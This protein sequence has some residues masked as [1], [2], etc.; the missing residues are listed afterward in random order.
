[1]GNEVVIEVSAVDGTGPT[2]DE[3][4]ASWLA[5]EKTFKPIDVRATNPINEAFM[6]QVRASIKAISAQ[7]LRIPVDA[8]TAPFLAQVEEVLQ[9]LATSAKADIPLEVGDAIEFRAQVQELVAQIEASTKAV[10]D[11][12][13]NDTG[14]TD[15]QQ[16]TVAASTATTGM[17][18][19]QQKLDQA[20][21]GGN[22]EQIA[23]ARADLAMATKEADQAT[24]ELQVA[25]EAAAAGAAALTDGEK[26]ATVAAVGMRDAMGPLWM[27][28]NVAQ[29]AMMGLYGGFGSTSAGAQDLSQQIVGLGNSAGQTALNLLGGNQTL[30]NMAGSL[31]LAGTSAAAFS[32]AFQ[33]G[34]ASMQQYKDALTHSRDAVAGLTMEYKSNYTSTGQFVSGGLKVKQSVAD[35]AG[36]VNRGSL[37][38]SSLPRPVQDAVNRFNNLNGVLPQV[39]DALNTLKDSEDATRQAAAALGFTMNQGQIDA[40][41]YGYGV[42][43]AAKALQDARAGSTYLEDATDKASITAGQ[44]VQSWKQLQQSVTSAQQAYDQAGQ[45]VANAEHSV[46]TAA[47]GVAAARHSEQQATIAVGTAQTAYTNAVYQEE[48][49]QQA[50]T[51]AR[52]AAAAALV[53]LQLQA[54]DAA[55]SALSANVSLFNAQNAASLMGVTPGNAQQI[56]GEQITAANEAQVAAA[57]A[58]IQAQNQVA[59][60]QNSS[61]DAQT[62]LNT[63]RQQGIDNNPQVVSAEHALAQAQQGVAT[64]A[65]GVSNAEYAQQQA[66]QAVANA[67]YAEQQASQAVTQAKIQQKQASDALATAED[68][69]TRSTDQNTLVGAQNRQMLE[70]LFT[71]YENETGNEQLAAQMTQRVGQQMGFTSGQIGD[72]I[73]SL[74]GLNGMSAQFSIT[75]TPSLNP[76]QL[77]Q[78]GNQLGMSFQAIE[79]VLPSQHVGTKTLQAAGGHITGP[80]GPTDDLIPAMLSNNEYVMPAHAVDAYGVSYMN[81]IRNHQA[82]KFAAGGPVG[83]TQALGLDLPVTAQWGALATV[84]QMMHALGGPPVKLPPAGSVD[85]GAFGGMPGSV[86]AVPSS[87]AANEAIMQAVFGTHGWG[88]GAEWAAAV[89]LEMMEA[90][91]NNLAQNPTSTAFG[92]GQ[93][94]DS[95]WASYGIP[96]TSDPG[97]QSEAMA[98]YIGAR[99]HDPLGAL[100]HERAFHWY[101]AGGPGSGWV[102]INDGGLEAVR[103]PNG[104]T[105]MPHANTAA[106][107]QQQALQVDVNLNFTGASDSGAASWFH[108]LVRQGVVQL[109]A[110]VN[111]QRVPVKVG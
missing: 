110:V 33:G 4:K 94:L 61:A 91:F 39:G 63:A 93:F 60:A 6:A 29:I 84:G 59:D 27:V 107:G 72:V 100:A 36:E 5:F 42:Q 21:A 65:Q 25:Q 70:N 90:G 23:K 95:T 12:E 56:A 64:A 102:G 73:G 14:L 2:K 82:P 74:N 7:A 1:M 37:A 9:T 96:K 78:I 46:S 30:Q 79:N 26:A 55:A 15:L 68:N 54:N 104:A 50:V 77:V 62:N 8:D 103:L 28:M 92:M 10:I 16:K 83:A 24:T 17:V 47:Q 97:L 35:I 48:Q 51:A 76:Q 40:E 31:N 86:P 38:L 22:D 105:V 45:S 44:A 57:V 101:A 99:Y 11:I 43:A 98:R 89:T 88:S 3:L 85:W 34:S 53:S 18:S 67:S 75:G 20:L 13:V 87:R 109:S 80:G 106:L 69:A 111:G 58:L 108:G 49:A 19:A 41:N 81:A 71:A 32:Q 66:Q 52:Q